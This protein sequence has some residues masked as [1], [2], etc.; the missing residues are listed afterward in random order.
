MDPT[1]LVTFLFK[2]PP[3]CRT[4][5]LLGS[6]DN[7]RHGYKMYRDRRRGADFWSGCFKFKDIVFDG[8]KTDWS[9]PR[10]GGLKQG[11]TYWYYFRLNDAI[12][13]F[14][15]AKDFTRGCP[16]L[17]GQTVNVID[18]PVEMEDLPSRPRSASFD[19]V[20]A[21][22]ELDRAHTLDP[23]D[24]WAALDPPPISKVHQRCISDFALNGRLETKPV[25]FRET[26][27][28]PPPSPVHQDSRPGLDV[29]RQRSPAD[30]HSFRSW[31]TWSSPPPSRGDASIFDAYSVKEHGA[32]ST[33]LSAFP[34]PGGC[35]RYDRPTT[36]CG[37]QAHGGFDSS[38]DSRRSVRSGDNDLDGSS[39]IYEPADSPPM[40]AYGS[41]D[42]RFTVTPACEDASP[43]RPDSQMPSEQSPRESHESFAKDLRRISEE[44]PG[45]V[46]S[47]HEGTAFDICSP[48]FSADTISSNGGGLNTPFRLSDGF[49]RDS[50]FQPDNQQHQTNGGAANNVD[51]SIEHI[52]ARFRQLGSEDSAGSLPSQISSEPESEAEPPQHHA[53][54]LGH[55][56]LPIHNVESAATLS[57]VSSSHAS[58]APADLPPQNGGDEQGTT[59]TS[60]ADAIFSELGYL[61]SSIA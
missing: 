6:W 13:A 20:G 47:D 37:D 16:L 22:A 14:D 60:F 9:K 30:T 4:V 18:V 3:E 53:R 42:W 56:A 33:S 17:P 46:A 8:D 55:Y 50:S 61:G 27:D 24:K 7:F 31:G 32:E 19:V 40:S 54:F 25:S 28:S 11:G 1:T 52:T 21:L 51:V 43:Q 38:F 35:G 12:E 36:R 44:S 41:V 23:A 26:K 10:S 29:P 5:E 39:F 57:K 58:I 34:R 15:D 49:T 2:A 45:E 48:T 59:T